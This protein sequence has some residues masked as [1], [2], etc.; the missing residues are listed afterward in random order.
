MS[1]RAECTSS[2]ST[3]TSIGE[4]AEVAGHNALGGTDGLGGT[5]RVSTGVGP[6]CKHHQVVAISALHQALTE[7]SA[8]ADA[9][10]Q[11]R[12]ERGVVGRRLSGPRMHGAECE[13][14][15]GNGKSE[16]RISAGEPPWWGPWRETASASLEASLTWCFPGRLYVDMPAGVVPVLRGSFASAVGESD[17]PCH[18]IEAID[19]EYSHFICCDIEPGRAG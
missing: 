19:S 8:D 4:P 10:A 7:K 11:G 15:R 17:V 16:V 1:L 14:E 5:T 9:E 3:T 12:G 13:E 2:T 18:P 6:Q